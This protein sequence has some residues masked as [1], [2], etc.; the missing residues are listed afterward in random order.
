MNGDDGNDDA[1]ARLTRASKGKRGSL[2][3]RVS[4][5]LTK[6][7]YASPLHR[8]KIGGRPP[9]K[10]LATPSDPIKGDG[11]AGREI[12]SGKL[13][14]RG[15]SEPVRTLNF[16]TVRA[17]RAWREWVHGFTW[18]RDLAA[19]SDRKK[20]AV[21]AEL[22]V[23]AWLAA[24][25][26][27]DELAWRG[28]LIG[29]RLLY[30]PLYAPYVLSRGEPTYRSLV[31]N[32][33]A[34]SARHLDKAYDKTA[35]GLPRIEAAAGLLA[36]G[37][38]LPEGAA[39]TVR[40]EAALQKAL[41]QFLLPGGG[42]V[43]RRPSDVLR[44]SELL[45]TLR[46]F[47]QARRIDVS[48]VLLDSI[49]TAS[50]GLKGLVLGDG[51]LAAINGGN[52]CDPER[53]AHALTLFGGSARPTRNGAASGFQRL[54]AGKSIIVAD[55]GPPPAT[56]GAHAGT[57][58]FEM[59]DGASRMIVNCG[60]PDGASA[61][62]PARL[63]DILRTTAAHS[64]LVVADTNST[65]MLADGKLGKGVGEVVVTRHESEDGSW[66]DATHDGYVR[67]FGLIHRRRIFLAADG[68]DLRGEDM[69]SPAG[70]RNLLRRKK[71]VPFD[72]RFHLGPGAEA[73]PTADGKGALI[74]LAA[75]Q[76]WQ[77]KARGGRLTV[78]D[79]LFVD[80]SGK[81]RTISQIVING[82]TNESGGTVNWSFKRASR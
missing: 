10:L 6:L 43:S 70:G 31:L 76:V 46:A 45:L 59:S 72:V 32:H 26:E 34:R 18:L 40:A 67:K 60:G 37:L 71:P 30:W 65:Q 28:D 73:T 75:G 68:R 55:A 38:I 35:E 1:S 56:A 25:R 58:A 16:A 53:V 66:L 74:K 15:H 50:A 82:Q 78:D 23:E 24:Y 54:S 22:A 44:L 12:A 39:R 9:L 17:P 8:R 48:P 14:Y 3:A 49:E 63:A 13:T 7:G 29:R 77:V 57:L 36:A 81:T 52:I 41:D 4:E 61:P 51:C 5:R 64:T 27:Y 21:V 11:L 19:A 62:L 79:S 2:G 33:L 69:V 80:E 42:V 47:Y 20:G